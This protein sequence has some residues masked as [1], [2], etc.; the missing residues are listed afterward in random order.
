[1]GCSTS[2]DA[3]GSGGGGMG[4]AGRGVV[5]ERIVPVIRDG[6]TQ[7]MQMKDN[8]MS[9]LD[10]INGDDG[11]D[12][13]SQ[14]RSRI[15][16][17]PNAVLNLRRKFRILDKQKDGELT[18][19]EFQRGM[20]LYIHEDCSEGDQQRAF[21][22]FDKDNKGSISVEEFIEALRPEMSDSRKETL[23]EA[24]NSM[25]SNGNGTI[26]LEDLKSHS[27]ASDEHM[28]QMINA[29]DTDAREDGTIDQQ[30]FLDYYTSM[31]ASIDDDDQ[32][33][34][35]IRSG[36]KLGEYGGEHKE[37]EAFEI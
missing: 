33:N 25:D 21:K 27:G 26:S 10:E 28:Q 1:M 2:M 16:S 30:E 13:L 23:M 5:E 20:N 35:M 9:A 37:A 32:F 34:Q 17:E 19:E 36:F 8:M 24:F 31:S 29:M 6:E 22:Y 14:L 7:A 15:A 4:D 11:G 12:I 18:F 3:N